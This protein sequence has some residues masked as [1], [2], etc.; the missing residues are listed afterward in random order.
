M[1][2]V[3]GSTA[4]LARDRLTLVIGFAYLV[5][6]AVNASLGAIN[7]DLRHSLHLSGALTG[8][9]GAFFGW[10]LLAAALSYTWVARFADTA[11]VVRLAFAAMGVGAVVLAAGRNV[12]ITLLGAS[13]VG[14]G[15]AITVLTAPQ[16]LNARHGERDRTAALTFVNA[17]SQIG[18]V[19]APLFI[20]VCLRSGI[21]WRWAL[22]IVGALGTVCVVYGARTTSIDRGVAADGE[23]RTAPLAH[24][25]RQ[26]LLRVRWLTLTIGIAIEFATLFWASA[27]LRELAGASSSTGAVGVGLFAGGMVVGRVVGP[28]VVRKMPAGR[29]LSGSFVLAGLGTLLLRAGPGVVVRLAALGVCGLGLALVYPVAFSRLYDAG[30]PDSDVRAVGALASG[31]AVTFSPLGFG[32][33]ADVWSVRW[34]LLALPVLAVLGLITVMDPGGARAARVTGTGSGEAPR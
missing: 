31:T 22:G 5:L 15:G 30:A 1:R 19:A 33:L 17:L 3:T 20:A 29:V 9:H 16:I 6:G 34:A 2:L 8:L 18:S 24:L 7:D 26:R 28:R 25:R 27:S 21:G 32:A 23:T 14:L 4:R 13:I 11:L 10:F 12:A